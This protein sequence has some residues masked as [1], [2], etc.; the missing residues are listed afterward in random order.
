MLGAADRRPV[1]RRPTRAQWPCRIDGPVLILRKPLRPLPA[2]A[3]EENCSQP[4]LS[5]IKWADAQTSRLADGLERM[6]NV[7]DLPI[8]LGAPCSDVSGAGCMG[9][10]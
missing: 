5:L 6:N 7:V 3:F 1:L 4:F 9:M 10:E 8:L 2:G